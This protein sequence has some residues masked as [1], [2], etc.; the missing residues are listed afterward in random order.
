MLLYI[1]TQ[2]KAE[3]QV[4]VSLVY[5]DAEDVMG[6]W[7]GVTIPGWRQCEGCHHVTPCCPDGDKT[8]M[9]QLVPAIGPHWAG[10]R[11]VGEMVFTGQW[12]YYWQHTNKLCS[13]LDWVDNSCVHVIAARVWMITVASAALSVV[14]PSGGSCQHQAPHITCSLSPATD[15]TDFDTLILTEK[16]RG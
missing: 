15:T 10:Q 16:G 14:T 2:Q 8:T 6:A 13:F 3:C 9:C 11:R 5:C 7:P 1:Y 4:I 12:Q